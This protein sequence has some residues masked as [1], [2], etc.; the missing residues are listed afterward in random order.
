MSKKNKHISKEDFQRY[1]KNQMTDA[2]RNAFERELQKHPFEAEALEGFHLISPDELTNDLKELESRI[3]AKKGKSKY[4]YWA[5]AATLL[6][7][8][9][10]SIIWFQLNNKSPLPEITE[11]KTIQKEEVPR[12]EKSGTQ[13]NKMESAQESEQQLLDSRAPVSEPKPEI[14]EDS[15]PEKKQRIEKISIKNTPEQAEVAA[16][17][18]KIDTARQDVTLPEEEPEILIRGESSMAADSKSSVAISPI[19]L[20]DKATIKPN[21]VKGKVISLADNQPLPGAVIQQKG[22]INGTIAD[23]NGNF[24]LQLKSD[25]EP[26]VVVS[27]VGM[28]TE[29][30]RPKADSVKVI[31]LE[32]SQLALDEVVVTKKASNRKKQT[33]GYTAAAKPIQDAPPQPIGGM[34]KFEDYL[35]K[36]AVLEENYSAKRAVVKLKIQFNSDGEITKIENTNNADSGIFEKAKELLINGPEWTPEFKN[37]ENIE[38][39]KDLKIVFRKKK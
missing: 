10:T 14:K 33:V 22:T 5:A 39:E 24:A 15:Q 13:K 18:L 3:G 37:G 28:E 25:S 17:E 27:F 11:T 30:F 34:D 36:M 19:T 21:E 20:E 38:S 31:G 4:R 29:E 12:L 8:I 26:S 7:L 35:E 1:L 23:K 32:P 9:S 6:L 16:W 2:E